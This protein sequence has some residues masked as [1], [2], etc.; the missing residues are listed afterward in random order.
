VFQSCAGFRL[1]TMTLFARTL[2]SAG[3]VGRLLPKVQSRR[4]LK[5]FGDVQTQQTRFKKNNKEEVNVPSSQQ[6]ASQK[7]K[8]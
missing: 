5:W 1:L 8:S 2:C 4:V 3:N 7:R 6:C